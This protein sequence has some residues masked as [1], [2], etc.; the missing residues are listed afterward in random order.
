MAIPRAAK[1]Q[2]RTRI[3]EEKEEQILEAALDVFSSHGFRGAT[4]DEIAEAAGMSKP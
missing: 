4:I 3:Q 1:T 2:R